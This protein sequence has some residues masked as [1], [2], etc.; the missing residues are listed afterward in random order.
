MPLHGDVHDVRI[1]RR[2]EDPFRAR[3]RGLVEADHDFDAA[4]GSGGWTEERAVRRRADA[5][6]VE[7][8]P[9][10]QAVTNRADGAGLE[11]DLAVGDDHHLP[12]GVRAQRPQRFVDCRDHLRA[13]ACDE[14][15]DPLAR[16]SPLAVAGMDRPS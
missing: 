3:R 11:S 10:R 8:R 13:A 5:D 12:R 4:T 1:A 15:V 6:R 14:P 7:P 16:V 9:V 2:G